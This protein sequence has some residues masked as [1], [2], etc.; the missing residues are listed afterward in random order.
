MRNIEIHLSE[1]A[2]PVDQVENLSF[3][4]IRLDVIARIAPRWACKLFTMGVYHGVWVIS[5]SPLSS[6]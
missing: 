2:L 1:Q 4:V 5:A 3:Y 6:G